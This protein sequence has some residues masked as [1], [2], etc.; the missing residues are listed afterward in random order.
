MITPE[1]IKQMQDNPGI[2]SVCIEDGDPGEFSLIASVGGKFYGL[3]ADGDELR[4]DR[5]H[6]QAYLR[7]TLILGTVCTYADMEP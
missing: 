5:F 6:P 4:P 2:Y 1:Q 3:I 7:Q